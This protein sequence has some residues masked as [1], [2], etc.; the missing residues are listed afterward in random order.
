MLRLMSRRLAGS[1]GEAL[2]IQGNFAQ[3]AQHDSGVKIATKCLSLLVIPAGLACSLPS[4]TCA[5]QRSLKAALSRK[6]NF[7]EGPAPDRAYRAE[8]GQIETTLH[9]AAREL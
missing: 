3:Q 2:R 7:R 8:L 9:C 5:V 4:S 6:G 1:A